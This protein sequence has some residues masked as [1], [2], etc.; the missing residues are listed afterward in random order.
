MSARMGKKMVSRGTHA[1][2]DDE[3]CIVEAGV[4]FGDTST[5][6]LHDAQ[7]ILGG[8]V[9]QSEGTCTPE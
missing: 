9:H 3:H 5:A 7:C 6:A 1:V 4:K 8:T 2:N